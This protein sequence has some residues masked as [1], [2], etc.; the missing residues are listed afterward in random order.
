MGG[1]GAP[2]GPGA[3][4]GGAGGGAGGRSG[5]GAERVEGVADEENVMTA[6][7]FVVEEVPAGPE[8]VLEGPEGRHAVSVKRLA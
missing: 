1:A 2:A 4:R 8:F 7:V 5:R 6:P 3:A